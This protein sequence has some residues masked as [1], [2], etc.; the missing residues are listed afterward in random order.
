VELFAIFSCFLLRHDDPLH[1]SP[2]ASNISVDIS[3]KT[4]FVNPVQDRKGLDIL[5]R[6]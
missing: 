4:D 6:N 2:N 1:F 5:F 3:V